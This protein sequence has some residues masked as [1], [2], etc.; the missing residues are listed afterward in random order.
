MEVLVGDLAAQWN[1]N[2]VRRAGELLPSEIK[3][4]QRE[5]ASRLYDIMSE[6]YGE[7]DFQIYELIKSNKGWEP[8]FSLEAGCIKS[9]YRPDHEDVF[10]PK[11]TAWGY[12]FLSFLMSAEFAWN[13][14]APGSREFPG[15]TAQRT[16]VEHHLEP[17]D[18]AVG[19]LEKLCRDLFG[20]EV[21]PH[22]VAV[23]DSNISYPF[24]ERP[25]DRARLVGLD[26]AVWMRH[27]ESATCSHPHGRSF[28]RR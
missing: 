2:V 28:R 25:E 19:Y 20:P 12:T 4:C 1:R 15:R 3:I 11:E 22:M 13:V 17:R 9:F 21:G 23:F 5:T 14:E 8:E 27:E 26:A 6:M 7:R 18:I 16:N 24:I 10:W